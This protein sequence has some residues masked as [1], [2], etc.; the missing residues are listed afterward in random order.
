MTQKKLADEFGLSER[1]I[2]RWET[3]RHRNPQLLSVRRVADA[4][5]LDPV[6][7]ESLIDAAVSVSAVC[8]G[9]AGR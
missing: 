1:T 5:S 2:H 3:G 7:H 4:L 8:E 9:R 6:E